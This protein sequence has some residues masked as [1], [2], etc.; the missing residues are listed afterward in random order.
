MG[1]RYEDLDH[2]TRKFMV[3]EI[4]MDNREDE[5][6]IAVTSAVDK[7]IVAVEGDNGYAVH[8]PGERAYVLQ[9]L[10]SFSDTLRVS[11]QITGMQVKA[12]ALD[13]LKAVITRFGK[14]ALGIVSTAAQQA[15]LDWLKTNFG[16]LLGMLLS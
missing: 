8:A 4:D 9:S 5:K 11:A 10:K 16:K 3:E 7:V 1:L 15:I 6:L 12:F 14:S 13:P 2:E